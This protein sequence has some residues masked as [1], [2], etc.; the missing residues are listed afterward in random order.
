VVTGLLT[1]VVYSVVTAIG[2][3][4]FLGAWILGSIA[5]IVTAPFSAL[6]S[7]LLYVDLRARAEGL[8]GETLRTE[9]A[10]TA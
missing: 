6:V 2:G 1:G 8:T 10:R 3:G 9:L 7:I 4:S 5:W